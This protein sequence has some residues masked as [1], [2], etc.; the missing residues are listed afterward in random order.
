MK[1]LKTGFEERLRL[2]SE[3]CI[4]FKDLSEYGWFIKEAEEEFE[5]KAVK[6]EKEAR[7]ACSGIIV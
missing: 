5:E 7:V 2:G 3:A 6:V 1:Q 4:A